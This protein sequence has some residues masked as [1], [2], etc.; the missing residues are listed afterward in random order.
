MNTSSSYI[1]IPYPC[2]FFTFADGKLMI[3]WTDLY[4][5]KEISNMEKLIITFVH[6]EFDVLQVQYQPLCKC[7]TML[8]LLY[9]TAD[10]T[11]YIVRRWDE[12]RYHLEGRVPPIRGGVPV[13]ERAGGRCY[14]RSA[15]V[16][17]HWTYFVWLPVVL[18]VQRRGRTQR[19]ISPASQFPL[20]YRSQTRCILKEE[21][22]G[23]V[24]I[25][26]MSAIS[27]YK[28]IGVGS[29]VCSIVLI[30]LWGS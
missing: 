28:T 27:A 20:L 30:V 12:S 21:K 5:A 9:I 29:I 22:C 23:L 3:P 18:L 24:L 4:S 17:L 8:V 14:D 2:R 6:D 25:S 11:F 7:N 13:G 16:I 15:S 10:C 26:I 1:F 19:K